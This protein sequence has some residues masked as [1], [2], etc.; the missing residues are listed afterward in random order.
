M[1]PKIDTVYPRN[2]YFSTFSKNTKK[3]ENHIN[4]TLL[5]VFSSQNGSKSIRRNQGGHAFLAPF[6]QATFFYPF[7]SSFGSLLVPFGSR[8]LTFGALWF[9]FGYL[10]APVGSLL[11]HFGS[12]LVPFGS[13]LVPFRIL[14]RTLGL[15]FRAFLI[16]FLIFQVSSHFSPRF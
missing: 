12:L 1:D 10:L 2:N 11:V 16:N 9:P 13:L 8:W 5:K 3:R 6:F 4:T 14:L 7:W 15:D